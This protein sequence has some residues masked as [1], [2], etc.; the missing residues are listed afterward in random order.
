MR[1]I[2]VILSKWTELPE[3]EKKKITKE[4]K[5]IMNEL[6]KVLKYWMRDNLETDPF[7]SIEFAQKMNE[8]TTE[9]YDKYLQQYTD[10]SV[11][12]GS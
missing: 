8:M 12:E 9:E 3:E 11:K 1:E 7:I 2:I 6:M 5:E 10:E 4:D